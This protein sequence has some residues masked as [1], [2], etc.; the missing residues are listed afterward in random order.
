MA[1]WFAATVVA[2]PTARELSLSSA[3]VS[4]LTLAVQLGFVL[5]SLTS[6]VLVLSDRY[7]PRHL[8]AVSALLAAASTAAI[9]LFP[10]NGS[11]SIAM[12]LLTG[13]SLEIGRASCR[14]RV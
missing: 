5:G 1:P 12:R 7:R 8:A 14:E 11:Q 3:A 4:W 13:A 2:E 10:L 6:A 9:A